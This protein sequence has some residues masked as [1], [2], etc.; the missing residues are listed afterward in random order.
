MDPVNLNIE[1]FA[2]LPHPA[3]Q[4]VAVLLVVGYG[5]HFAFAGYFL[6]ASTQLAPRYRLGTWL[7]AVVMV[8]AGLSLLR[9]FSVWNDVFS[10]DG[11]AWTRKPDEVF[12]NAYRYANWT[13]TIP[14][15]LV[16]LLLALGLKGHDLHRRFAL[17]TGAAWLMI[18]TGLIGQ[19][20]ESTSIG[21][22]LVWGAIS[23]VPFAYLVWGVRDALIEGKR[24][25]PARLHVWHDN[26]FWF[27]LFFWGL[28]AL[29]YMVPA[30][31]DGPTAI[32]VRQGMFTVADVFSKVVYGVILT[33]YLLRKSALDGYAPAIEALEGWPREPAPVSSAPLPTPTDAPRPAPGE[34]MG[35]ATIG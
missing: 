18:W 9:E 25:S 22:L 30:F 33:R 6:A 31:S 10:F 1:N 15:L 4:M 34:V 11:A 8:A 27:F 5:T 32:V 17:L 13:I 24:H 20:Y 21:T 14:L 23:T 3:W 35:A 16:Q 2:A 26:L 7:S 28:Y 29:A 12:S 19:F